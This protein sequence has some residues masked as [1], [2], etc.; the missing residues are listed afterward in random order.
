MSYRTMLVH[1]DLSRHASERI[2]LAAQLARAHDA[3]LIG[4]AAIGVSRE[5]FPHGYQ[6]TPGSLEASY[7]D[8]LRDNATRGLEQFGRIAGEAEVSHEARLVCDL[9]SDALARLARF[10]DL[11]IVSQDDLAEA[12]AETIG[13]IPEY[14]AFTSA[15]PVLVLPCAPVAGDLARH[16]LVA[17]NGSKESSS[18]MQA[19]IPLLQRA[20][21]V[22]VVSFRS[23]NDTDLQEVHYQADLAA[24]LARHQVRAEILAFDRH[25]DGGHALLT[26]AEQE[27]YDLIVMGCYG[28]SQF[29]ELFLGG[30]TRTVLQDAKIPILMAR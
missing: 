3:H 15:R 14:V 5:V 21:R 9:A 2:R 18:A 8:P 30:V 23:P 6:S 11:V 17:W 1:V 16:I 19:A 27:A 26:M 25:I 28:H 13:R 24:F 22:S 12:L 20:T 7:F 10:S 29:R 4:T